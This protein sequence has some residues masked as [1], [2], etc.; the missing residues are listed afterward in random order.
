MKRNI[1]ATTMI[2]PVISIVS[3]SPH[4]LSLALMFKKWD[5]LLQVQI[6]THP[7]SQNLSENS[8][9]C[10]GSEKGLFLCALSVEMGTMGS[11]K[12]RQKG[13]LKGGF[14]TLAC[15]MGLEHKEVRKMKGIRRRGISLHVVLEDLDFGTKE[16]RRWWIWSQEWLT[17]LVAILFSIF[18]FC[19]VW[20]ILT[21]VLATDSKFVYIGS[22]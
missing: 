12:W 17:Q 2:F 20:D 9:F 1:M 3:D 19:P 4:A 15:E 21:S 16:W 6:W 22:E 11:W 5:F 18:Y 7:R 8:G 14:G 13:K 10:R